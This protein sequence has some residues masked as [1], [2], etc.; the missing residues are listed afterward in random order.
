MT[1]SVAARSR[2]L[3]PAAGRIDGLFVVALAPE[4]LTIVR[5]GGRLDQLME[6]ALALADHPR[7]MKRLTDERRPPDPSPSVQGAL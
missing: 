3:G 5:L 1:H 2:W 7:R 6:R 4:E